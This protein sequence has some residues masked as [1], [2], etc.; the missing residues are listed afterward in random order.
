MTAGEGGGRPCVRAGLSVRR[1]DECLGTT[2]SGGAWDTDTVLHSDL[3]PPIDPAG[4]LEVAHRAGRGRVR[5]G[6]RGVRLSKTATMTDAAR[7][8]AIA[9]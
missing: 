1:L 8:A 6:W 4:G 5:L 2:S 7:A 3:V 9:G